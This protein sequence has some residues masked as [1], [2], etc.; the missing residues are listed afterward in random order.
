MPSSEEVITEAFYAVR[1][2]LS[3]PDPEALDTLIAEDYRGFDIR[4]GVETRELILEYYRPGVCRLAS[5]EVE[6]LRTHVSG[7]LGMLTGLGNLSGSYRDETFQHTVRFCDVFVRR[8][9][10]W[11]LL[12]GQTT[13]VQP[14]DEE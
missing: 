12:F 4:G 6:D 10:R 7:N 9:S 13:E 11:L 5:L 3:V 1:N 2:A 14:T 8:D